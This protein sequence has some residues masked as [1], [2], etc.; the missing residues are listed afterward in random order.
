MDARERPLNNELR[1]PVIPRRVFIRS[2]SLIA[3][4][5]RNDLSLAAVACGLYEV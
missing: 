3:G 4:L 2:Q 1:G 5:T